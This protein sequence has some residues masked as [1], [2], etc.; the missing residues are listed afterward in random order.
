LKYG[1]KGERFMVYKIIKKHFIFV[2]ILFSLFSCVHSYYS[3]SPKLVETNTVDS[4]KEL[5]VEVL[6]TNKEYVAFHLWTEDFEKVRDSLEYEV[7]YNTIFEKDKKYEE[8]KIRLLSEGLLLPITGVG[9]IMLGKEMSGCFGELSEAYGMENDNSASLF[10]IMGGCSIIG[11]V[12]FLYEAVSLKQKE[13]KV[14]II[15]R[16]QKKE[17]NI[18]NLVLQPVIISLSNTEYRKDYITDK[19]GIVSISTEDI[20]PYLPDGFSRITFDIFHKGLST[21]I[22]VDFNNIPE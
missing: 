19:E 4:W 13:A 5:K 22:T 17:D 12:A 15:T 21:Q 8:V 10:Y 2:L 14:K 3:E 18:K 9:A 6:E 20:L 11:G 16:T 1:F 7:L